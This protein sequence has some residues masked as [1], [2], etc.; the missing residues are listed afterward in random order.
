MHA[1][2]CRTAGS[3]VAPS[4]RDHSHAGNKLVDPPGPAGTSASTV[5]KSTISCLSVAIGGMTSDVTSIA[6]RPASSVV[7]IAGPGRGSATVSDIW[8]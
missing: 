3:A 5:L 2:T 8:L 1:Q 7:A 6:S 4:F